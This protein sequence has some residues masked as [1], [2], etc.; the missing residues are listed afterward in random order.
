MLVVKN[1]LKKYN[2]IMYHTPNSTNKAK[3]TKFSKPTSTTGS[4]GSKVDVFAACII[5][6]NHKT[7][8]IK[9][10]TVNTVTST[11]HV[12]YNHP[13]SAQATT[14][15]YSSGAQYA[16]SPDPRALE[17][18][19][20]IKTQALLH[21][22]NTNSLGGISKKARENWKLV[23]VCAAAILLLVMFVGPFFGHVTNALASL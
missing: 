15:A 19:Q 14:H 21:Q 9:P 16:N 1:V 20:Q 23:V 18:I 6:D 4:S 13:A 5:V 22:T 11:D 3:L 17:R 7:V 2:G 10:H 12:V 8:T